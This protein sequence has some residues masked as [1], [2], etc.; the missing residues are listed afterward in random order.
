MLTFSIACSIIC[1]MSTFCHLMFKT[2]NHFTHHLL[3]VNIFHCLLHHL[4][5][6]HILHHLTNHLLCLATFNKVHHHF[7]HLATLYKVC[8]CIL[9]SSVVDEVVNLLLSN[10]HGKVCHQIITSSSSSSS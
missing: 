6:V 10:L 3:H 7:F 4:L 1:S 9:G 2:S 5:H 8:D